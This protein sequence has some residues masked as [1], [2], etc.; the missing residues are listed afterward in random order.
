[1]ATKSNDRQELEPLSL[2]DLLFRHGYEKK[3]LDRRY[4]PGMRLEIAQLL[5]DWKM[6]GYYLCFTEQ[7][8]ND[9]KIDNHNEEQRRVALLDAWEQR[10]GDRATYLKMVEALHRQGRADQVEKLCEKIGDDVKVL[11][12]SAPPVGIDPCKISS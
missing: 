10:E 9:I 1:M 12:E 11:D 2:E 5:D 8:L 4:T 3:D 6:I 7:K